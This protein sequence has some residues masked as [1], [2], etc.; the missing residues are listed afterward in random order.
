V[1][2]AID[3]APIDIAPIDL[4][5]GKPALQSSVSPAL[6]GRDPADDA[7][8]ATAAPSGLFCQTDA[9]AAPWWQVDLQQPSAI[10]EI[11]LLNRRE[12][13]EGLRHF[14]LL[15]SLTGEPGSWVVI[16]RKHSAAVFGEGDDIPYVIR[17]AVRCVA[18]FLRLRRET[19]GVLHF[20]QC[21]VFGQPLTEDA[22]GAWA[23]MLEQ[24]TALE[25]R[26][27]E[28]ARTLAAG[29]QG[30]AANIGGH[31]VFVDTGAYSAPLQQALEEGYYEARELRVLQVALRR[32]DRVLEVGTAIGAL[33]MAAAAIIGASA[34]AT[35]DANPAMVV[36]AQRNF[37]ANGLAEIGAR[38][39]VLRNRHRWVAGETTVD[40]FVSRDFW[41]SRL[42]AAATDA[43][44]IRVEQVPLRC[45]EDE[46]AARAATVL[47]CDI[48]GGEADLLMGADLAGLRLIIMETHYWAGGRGRIDRMVKY[49]QDQGFSLNL[50]L[51]APHILVLDRE[52]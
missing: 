26:R 16:H 43:D 17:P 49:L 35:F 41:Y 32:D 39:G 46:I 14:S 3:L 44:I 22:A 11:R 24:Q 31:L 48:E 30:H 4:A 7:A 8:I 23:D 36:D 52:A 20:R 9:E 10:D 38:V 12:F 40:F 5:R 47:V 27:V 21:E 2:Q 42:F 34:V 51:T 18:R 19:P 6:G 13:A 50:D 15:A 45:L 1:P 28:A 29:R 25:T 37:A 33:A